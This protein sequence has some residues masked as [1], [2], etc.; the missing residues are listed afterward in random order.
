MRCWGDGVSG[1]LGYGNTTDIG[2]TE[3]PASAGDVTVG[4]D[5]VQIAAGYSHTCAV[6]STGKVRCWGDGV[7]GKLGYSNTT[8]IGD[9]ETPASVGDITIG[10]VVATRSIAAGYNHTCAL[11]SSGK[12]RCWGTGSYGRLG[13]GNTNDIG[14]SETPLSAGS[15]SIGGDV[16]QL[17]AGGTHTCSLISTGK[18][19]CWGK[20]DY[21]QLGYGN[22]NNIGDDETPASAGDI[23]I[24]GDVIQL[25]SGDNHTCAL[26][27]TGKVRCWGTGSD[28]R[29]GYGDTNEIGDNEAP[30]SAGDVN[31]GGDAV[32]ISAG[33]YHTCALLSTGN[34]RCWGKNDYGQ[35]G[36]G[37][38]QSIGDTET[39]ASAGDVDVGGSVKQIMA[40]QRHT[41]ALLSS[42]AVRCWGSSDNGRL[43][44]V[45]SNHIGDNEAPSSAGNIDVGGNVIQISNSGTDTCAI[46]STGNVRCWG[47][48]G[49]QLGYGNVGDIG[50]N[51]TPASVGDIDVG[52]YVTSIVNGSSHTCAL[53]GAGNIRCWGYSGN[54]QLGYGNTSSIGDNEAPSIAGDVAV[55]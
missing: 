8:D 24:G 37:H 22:A 33:M 36:Y 39:P 2:D 41:C 15:V 4:G 55:W 47:L 35:L 54:G 44:Y 51:E 7:N 48:N 29:L 17:T 5:V 3:T 32:Q 18:V 12:V 23:S 19:R 27:S 13:Y 28:G 45:N 31:V 49:P 38:T 42:G 14:D 1:Q 43:G 20:N 30:S 40:G 34:V 53:L 52:G 10:G 21:G 16:I 11:L 9:T 6:L 50:D 46:L 25:T 26:L